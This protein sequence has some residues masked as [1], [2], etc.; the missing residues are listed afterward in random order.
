MYL[1]R[2]CVYVCSCLR[3]CTRRYTVYRGI[4]IRTSIHIKKKKKMLR[5]EYIC[6]DVEAEERGGVSMR[7]GYRDEEESVRASERGNEKSRKEFR[8]EYPRPAINGSNRPSNFFLVDILILFFPRSR[9][10]SGVAHPA[11]QPLSPSPHLSS[12]RH[13]F[14]RNGKFVQKISPYCS[15]W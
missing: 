6:G 13:P 3:K 4:P 15:H 5:E 1:A 12:R 10:K 11:D 2:E 8:A 7:A 9:L 14:K